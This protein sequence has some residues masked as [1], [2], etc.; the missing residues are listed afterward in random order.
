MSGA[1]YL[2]LVNENDEEIGISEKLEAHEKGLMHRAFSVVLFQE[3][4]PAL[5]LIQQRAAI[6]YHCPLMWAN[7]CCSHP[8]PGETPMAGAVRRVKEELGIEVSS[9]QYAGAFTYR[10]DVGSLIEHEFDHVFAG[11][12]SKDAAIPFNPAEV[13]TTEWVD[14]RALPI[15]KYVPWI[16]KVIYKSVGLGLF[17]IH[18]GILKEC[19]AAA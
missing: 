5:M 6:K 11:V 4:D 17:P 2:V 7:A 3:E 14:I 13:A 19:E 9:L 15:R 8:R 10:A 1:E 16:R 18:E 12:L